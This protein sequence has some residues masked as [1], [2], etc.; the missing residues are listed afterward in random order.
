METL[1]KYL[2]LLKYFVVVLLAPEVLLHLICADM[3]PLFHHLLD[4]PGLSD[5]GD[6]ILIGHSFK[7]S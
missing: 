2:Q 7:S 4:G 5:Y 3:L 1:Y 6:L